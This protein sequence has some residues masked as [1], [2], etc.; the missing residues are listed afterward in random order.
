MSVYTHSP[1]SEMGYFSEQVYLLCQVADQL[2]IQL[3][4]EYER[5]LLIERVNY[6]S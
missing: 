3:S 2:D 5:G 1:E 6:S 4:I